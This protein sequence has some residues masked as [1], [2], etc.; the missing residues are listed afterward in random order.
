MRFLGFPLLEKEVIFKDDLQKIF[1][2]RPFPEKEE[3]PLIAKKSELKDPASED[4]EIEE[5]SPVNK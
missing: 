3:V 2:N 1:G 4:S 5:E